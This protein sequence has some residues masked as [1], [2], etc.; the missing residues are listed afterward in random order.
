MARAMLHNK[1]MARNL[2]GEVV[3]TACHRLI[4]CIS[5]SVPKRLPMSC[6]RE[7][8]QMLSIS[9]F[10]EVL[11]SFSR[12][13]RMWENLTPEVMKEYFWDTPL[14]ARLIKYTTKE[15]RR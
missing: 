4:G 2:W 9:K 15:P 12:I 3:N 5:E 14:Q 1:N 11:V 8:N 6:G 10:L 13:E 7:G